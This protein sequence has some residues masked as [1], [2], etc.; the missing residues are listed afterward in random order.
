MKLSVTTRRFPATPELKE[1]ASDRVQKLARLAG[2]TGDARLV[3]WTERHRKCA[4]L[5]LRTR[6]AELVGTAE[7]EEMHVSIDQVVERMERRLRKVKDKR[8]DR[9][10]KAALA[11]ALESGADGAGEEA[12]EEEGE[13]KAPP[14]RRSR[15]KR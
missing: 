11:T 7:S 5:S 2:R 10:G 6:G 3:L 1:Y 8:T 15:A 14:A 13:G 9:K 4:E 12:D